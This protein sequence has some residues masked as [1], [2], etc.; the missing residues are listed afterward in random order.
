M[1]NII[2][3]NI[4][5]KSKQS[6]D[7]IKKSISS[8]KTS[9]NNFFT[10]KCQDYFEKK[11][12][13][14]K[15]LLTTSCSDALEMSAILINIQEGDEVIIPS[16]NFVS[17]A[18]AFILRG[19]KIIFA[20]SENDSPN[21]DIIDIQK[22]ITDKT[23]AIVVVHY[24]GLSCEI[25]K[26]KK[27]AVDNNIFLVEDAA[28]AIDSFYIL[29]KRQ[30]PLGSFGDFATFSFHETKNISC[31]E[32]GMLVVNNKDFFE[33]SEIIWEKGT[34]RSSFRRGEINKYEWI[35]IGSSFLPSDITAAYLYSQIQNL[36]KI[37]QKRKYIW[38]R[39]YNKLEKIK[40]EF[41]ILIPRVKDY[42]YINGHIFYFLCSSKYDRDF[43]LNYL[44][45]KGINASFHYLSL[46][47]SPYFLNNFKSYDLYNSDK[48]SN[49]LIRL[50]LYFYLEDNH[51]D[52]IVLNIVNALKALYN[53]ESRTFEN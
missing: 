19:A 7:N 45:I 28:H 33:R 42:Q 10:K 21:I 34:N 51:I 18:N 43:V 32:G 16:Y 24:A 17:S 9:G 3:F 30:I 47:K 40:D 2:P 37:Q 44:K 4:S 53:K 36:D 41:N 50:P 15:C 13:F 14:K 31:G 25:K 26:I 12:G 6:I 49:N 20:D 48:F 8:N 35:D 22:K 39:Y 27:L 38:E 11:Y 5:Y 52:F 29:N 1:D 23:K 46:N